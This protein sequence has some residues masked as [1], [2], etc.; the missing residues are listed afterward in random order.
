MT[1]KKRHNFGNLVAGKPYKAKHTD[2]ANAD[3]YCEPLKALP[4]RDEVLPPAVCSG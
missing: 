1:D 2:V 4:Y 3:L